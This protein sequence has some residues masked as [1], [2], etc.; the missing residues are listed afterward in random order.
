MG[1][2]TGDWSQ[3]MGVTAALALNKQEQ[4]VE[5]GG[6]GAEVM[7]GGH[8]LVLRLFLGTVPLGVHLGHGALREPTCQL[9]TPSS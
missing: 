1:L 8:S 7:L 4:E 9:S 3:G 2:R 5:G 6:E